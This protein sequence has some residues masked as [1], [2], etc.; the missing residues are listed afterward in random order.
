MPKSSRGVMRLLAGV[1][2]VGLCLPVGTSLAK[3]DAG[4]DFPRCIHA[5]NE[6]R[7]ACDDRCTTDCTAL[8]PGTP[9]KALRDACILACKDICNSQSDD[10]KLVCKTGEPCPSPPC[11]GEP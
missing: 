4:R 11:T 8:Y 7:R 9:N 10:C 2:A 5:C 1:V 6:A 3:A